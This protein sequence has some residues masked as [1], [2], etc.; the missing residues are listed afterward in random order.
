MTD[1]NNTT[2]PAA[3]VEP[4]AAELREQLKTVRD[5]HTTY[6]TQVRD[7]AIEG[8]RDNMWTLPILNTVL[9]KLELEPFE[10]KRVTRSTVAINVQLDADTENT[11]VGET[12]MRQLG[13]PEARD[14]LKEAIVT[15]VQQHVTGSPTVSVSSDSLSVFVHTG[16]VVEL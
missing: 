12:A 4:S 11:Y 13:G 10:P 16:H 2:A 6:R 15:V 7:R 14:A 3:A 5:E 1:E 9:T 8:Y